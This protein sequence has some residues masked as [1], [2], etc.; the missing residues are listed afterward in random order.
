M[1]CIVGVIQ[2]VRNVI[3]CVWKRGFYS[4]VNLFAIVRVH[5]ALVEKFDSYGL[6]YFLLH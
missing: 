1:F 2:K 4:F 3:F 5:F 6:V